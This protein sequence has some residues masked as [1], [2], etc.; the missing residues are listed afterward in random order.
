M[1]PRGYNYDPH[2]PHQYVSDACMAP[3]EYHGNLESIPQ[4]LITV[5][6][7]EAQSKVAEVQMCGAFSGAVSDGQGNIYFGI[8]T[9]N[10]VGRLDVA[11][12]VNAIREKDKSSLERLQSSKNA[13]GSLFLDL[14]EYTLVHPGGMQLSP[15]LPEF[16]PFSIGSDCRDLN[17][18]AVDAAH[19]R[20]FA[21]CANQQFHVVS[22]DRGRSI[23]SLVIGPGVDAM[24]YD[25]SRG[26]IFT[27]NGGGYGS[28]TVI[29]QTLND[30]YTVVQNLPTMERARTLALDPSSGNLYLVTDLHGADL[31]NTPANGIGKLTLK[32][33]ENSFQVLVIG[34]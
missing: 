24:A 33:V 1:L 15:G 7:P 12:L 16:T 29:R 22:T 27:A 4:S 13:D 31:R 19:Y 3:S 23:A 17:A 28:V 6:D 21:A 20:L 10:Q 18:L 11:S 9:T 8:S 30:D 2:K 14:R 5:L 34:N 26:L 32:P 25:P